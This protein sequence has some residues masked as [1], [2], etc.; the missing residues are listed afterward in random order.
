MTHPKLVG[1]IKKADVP[2]E[3]AA[4]TCCSTMLASIRALGWAAT[5]QFNIEQ[6]YGMAPPVPGG[7]PASARG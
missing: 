5:L 1:M 2:D 6:R 3:S 7:A 4:E